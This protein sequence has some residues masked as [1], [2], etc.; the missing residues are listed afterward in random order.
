MVVGLL[1]PS[2]KH[3]VRVSEAVVRVA[4]LMA[5]IVMVMAMAVH[6]LIQQLITRGLEPLRTRVLDPLVGFKLKQHFRREIGADVD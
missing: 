2:Y 5:M 1:L 4:V 3:A 6:C